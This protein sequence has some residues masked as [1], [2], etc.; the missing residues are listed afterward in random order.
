MSVNN[1][2][3]PDDRD[4]IRTS[5]AVKQLAQGRSNAVGTFTLTAGATTTTVTATFCAI[6]ST[7]LYTPQTANAS[8]EIGNGTIYITAANVKNGSFV[9]THANNAQVDRTFSYVCLG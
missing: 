5:S 2:P 6:G 4:L 1:L 7:V 8:A 9:V 3:T